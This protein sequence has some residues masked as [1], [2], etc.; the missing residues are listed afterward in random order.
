MLLKKKT[1]NN[2]TSIE[3]VINL[4]EFENRKFKDFLTNTPLYQVIDLYPDDDLTY[5]SESE[6]N[7]D[8][9]LLLKNY[10]LIIE[11]EGVL[12]LGERLKS[13]SNVLSTIENHL[14]NVT[15]KHIESY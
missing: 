15:D 5:V 9:S 8:L 13:I 7:D 11:E 10:K 12:S 3:V 14:E 2:K 1:T 6:V 4:Q